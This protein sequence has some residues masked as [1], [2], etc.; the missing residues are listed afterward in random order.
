MPPPGPRVPPAPVQ[1]GGFHP[2]RPGLRHSRGR[3]RGE[4]ARA[5]GARPRGPPTVRISR[6]GGGAGPHGAEA[7]PQGRWPGDG[8]TRGVRL[9]AE[10]W[11]ARPGDV[12]PCASAEERD[13][14]SSGGGGPGRPYQ[15]F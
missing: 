8:A 5:E 10:A 12:D 11:T 14:R 4:A 7:G 6:V 13:P 1:D 3:S 2:P 15:L 9:R